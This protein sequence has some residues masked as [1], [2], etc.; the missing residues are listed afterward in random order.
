M[1]FHIVICIIVKLATAHVI[2]RQYVDP[3]L[4]DIKWIMGTFFS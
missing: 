1:I 3:W 2:H 4:G